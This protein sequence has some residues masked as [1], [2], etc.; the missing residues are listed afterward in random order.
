MNLSDQHTHDIPDHGTLEDKILNEGADGGDMH[1]IKCPIVFKN[2]NTKLK[3]GL[4]L[5]HVIHVF[6]NCDEMDS[7]VG[8][9]ISEK[10]N[11][12]VF[13]FCFVGNNRKIAD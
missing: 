12:V 11:T 3:Y 8:G 5:M 1:S 13:K 4:P 9:N 7:S 6:D 10:T 2:I